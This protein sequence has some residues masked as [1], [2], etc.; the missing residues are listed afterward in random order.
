M[1]NFSW[2]HKLPGESRIHPYLVHADS[3]TDVKNKGQIQDSF[4][5]GSQLCEGAPRYD[6]AKLSEKLH[7]IEKKIGS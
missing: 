4:Q 3:F 2:R 5:E 1:R 6:F 7:E